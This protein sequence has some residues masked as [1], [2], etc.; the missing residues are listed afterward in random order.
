MDNQQQP[1]R[2]EDQQ[3]VEPRSEQRP[4]DPW[5]QAFNS[6]FQKNERNFEY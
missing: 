3:K 4:F 5:E 1:R 2:N 6:D